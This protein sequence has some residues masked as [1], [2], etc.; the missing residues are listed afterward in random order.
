MIKIIR[1]IALTAGLLAAYSAVAGAATQDQEAMKAKLEKKLNEPFLA[2]SSWITDFDLAKKES[3]KSGKPI[4][5]Y[6]TRSYSY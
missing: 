2:K 6:F 4:F 5:A 3:V 1:T